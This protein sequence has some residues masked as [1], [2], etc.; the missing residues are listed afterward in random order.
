[1]WGRYLNS[2]ELTGTLPSELGTMDALVFLCVRHPRPPRLNACV[3][4]G[5]RAER[6]GVWMQVAGR[7]QS[8]G[9]TAHR[10][11]HHERADPLVRALPLPTRLDACAVTWL[12]AV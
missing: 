2:N 8:H 5:L 4:T 12:W 9:G 11:W 10:A 6:G 3:V 1:M 7:E